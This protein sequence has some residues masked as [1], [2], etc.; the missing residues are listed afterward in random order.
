MKCPSSKDSTDRGHLNLEPDR[1]CAGR[2]R[3]PNRLRERRGGDL[4]EVRRKREARRKSLRNNCMVTRKRSDIM[5]VEK[6]LEKRGRGIESE[7]D[8]LEQTQ[9]RDE[10]KIWW[11]DWGKITKY[12]TEQRKQ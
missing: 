12:L 8:E 5:R 7:G 6:S 3:C 9:T 4:T 1:K 10:A 2:W 11:H